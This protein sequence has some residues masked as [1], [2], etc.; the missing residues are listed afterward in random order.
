[1]VRV[2]SPMSDDVLVVD[3]YDS[4]T[5]NLTA[6]IAQTGRRFC[7]VPNDAVP[8]DD[9]ARFGQILISPG[10]GVPSEAGGICRL[11][12]E[13]AP[14]KSILGVCL[15]HQAIA[16][17]F[18]GVLV[19]LPRPVHGVRQTVVVREPGCRL[20]AGL[21]AGFDAGFYHSWTVAPEPFPSVLNVTAVSA[22]G[23]VM[24]LSHREYDV[25]GVQFHPESVMTPPGREIVGNWL[26]HG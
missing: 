14:T 11:I 1:M 25:H 22:G 8:W 13:Y 5:S 7:V 15:G 4:F 16:E 2:Y 18:G 17:V 9:L 20:F 24:A 21:A 10:P 3:N 26:R 6:L 12:R 19:R 23:A